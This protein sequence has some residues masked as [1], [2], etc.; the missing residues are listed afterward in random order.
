MSRQGLG[1]PPDPQ[2]E[3]LSVSMW[4]GLQELLC[5]LEVDSGHWL[6]KYSEG[7]SRRKGAVRFA[8]TRTVG[9]CAP[10]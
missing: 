1:A 10:R 8:R 7:Y 6:L 9:T 3:D 2:R 5:V 4:S